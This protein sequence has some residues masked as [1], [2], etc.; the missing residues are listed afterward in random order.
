M[1]AQ[2]ALTGRRQNVLARMRKRTGACSGYPEKRC[3]PPDR[4]RV[5]F[6]MN[7]TCRADNYGRSFVLVTGVAVGTSVD[8]LL[9]S[10]DASRSSVPASDDDAET[11]AVPLTLVEAASCVTCF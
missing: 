1:E 10:T 3:S 4:V 9:P 5:M 2:Y 7:A 6:T 11:E 8:V